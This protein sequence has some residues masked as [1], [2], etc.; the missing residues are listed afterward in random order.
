[1]C[2]KRF[3]L[4]KNNYQWQRKKERGGVNLDLLNYLFVNF[5][6][7]WYLKRSQCKK[8][9]KNRVSLLIFV[10]AFL[11]HY[12]LSNTKRYPY[13]GTK[14]NR[15]W[16][17]EETKTYNRIVNCSISF[18]LNCFC[19]LVFMPYFSAS[20]HDSYN[21]I[22]QHFRL[23]LRKERKRLAKYLFTFVIDNSQWNSSIN[24]NLSFRSLMS[25]SLW[26]IHADIWLKPIQYCKATVLQ[27]KIN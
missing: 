23:K 19:N 24:P 9:K 27:L 26:L 5:L 4:L 14:H 22:Y 1:M 11:L 15:D 25:D 17:R 12:L 6:K 16:Q 18:L 21:S 8:K 13:F 7:N 3:Y 2:E 20:V 10:L